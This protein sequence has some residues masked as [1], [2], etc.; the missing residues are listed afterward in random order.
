MSTLVLLQVTFFLWIASPQE[1]FLD[2]AA[3]TSPQQPLTGGWVGG[4]V[5]SA[6]G[7][8]TVPLR[9]ELLQLNRTEYREGD[10]F[11]YEVRLRNI[12]N[13]E[14]LI[15]WEP[16]WSKFPI[17]SNTPP[18]AGFK[19][20]HL[21]VRF[22]D[23][24]VELRAISAHTL[25]GSSG[26]SSSLLS[27]QPGESARIRGR[28]RFT[29]LNLRGEKPASKPAAPIKIEAVLHFAYGEATDDLAALRVFKSSTVEVNL[30]AGR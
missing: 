20:A 6:R 29:F 12:T 21:V 11:V 24:S 15:P 23:S 9:I 26:V 30:T 18:P 7:E 10:D 4:G 2:L 1:P 16:D 3:F 25:F 14:A 8:P 5:G 19:S 17:G 28:G 13:K 22:A 27:L